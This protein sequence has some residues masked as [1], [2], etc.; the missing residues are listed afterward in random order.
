MATTRAHANRKIRQE[1]L[2][3]QIANQKHEQH[4]FEILEE[5][6]EPGVEIS[7]LELQ[8]KKLII[9]TKLALLKK[10]IPDVKQVEISG[11]EDAPLQAVTRIE[12]VPLT[13][14]S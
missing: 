8:K 4:I 6:R 12:L 3:E 13:K 9:D 2:R 14:D 7:S 5:L 10:Y 11:D 1:A